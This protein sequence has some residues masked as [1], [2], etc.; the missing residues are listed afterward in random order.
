MPIDSGPG[1][2]GYKYFY[3]TRIS[4]IGTLATNKKVNTRNI[5]FLGGL[6]SDYVRSVHDD[7]AS[8]VDPLTRKAHGR[9]LL[10]SSKDVSVRAA[11][12]NRKNS[13]QKEVPTTA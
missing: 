4:A 2:G 1:S 10:R 8:Y 6:R 7:R 11:G 3:P 5:C 9:R 12:G 13:L